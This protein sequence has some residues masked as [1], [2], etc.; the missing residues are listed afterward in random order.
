MY[1]VNTRPGLTGQTK[2]VPTLEN[3]KSYHE[4]QDTLRTQPKH[5]V[6]R[7]HTTKPMLL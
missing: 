5:N 7:Q 2:D 4:L 1:N 3:A 6:A